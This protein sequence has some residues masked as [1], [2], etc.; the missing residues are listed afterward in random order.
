VASGRCDG[1]SQWIV[2]AAPDYVVSLKFTYVNLYAGQWLKVRNGLEPGAD[3]LAFSDGGDVV[4]DVTSTSTEVLV[5]FY[6]P[7]VDSLRRRNGYTQRA[8]RPIHVHGFIASFQ[9]NS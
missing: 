8:T 5:E 4:K 3:L 6:S 9:T 1:N 7:P 2:M